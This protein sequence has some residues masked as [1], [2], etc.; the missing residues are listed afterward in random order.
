MTQLSMVLGV[1]T[2]LAYLPCSP[3]PVGLVRSAIKTVPLLLFSLSA[4]LGNGGAFLVA[5]L[6][7]SA[8]GDFALSR[9][10]AALFLYGLSAF[11]LAHVVYILHFSGLADAPLYEAFANHPVPAL[12]LVGLVVSTE[13]WLIPHTGA[14]RWPV[15]IYVLIIGLMGLSA[16]GAPFGWAVVGA[17][18][19]IISDVILAVQ[20]FR[21]SETY[22][23]RSWAGYAV[24]AF[25]VSGQFM[26]LWGGLHG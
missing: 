4:Y 6:F 2:A 23:Y 12:A 15:R 21:M 17:G 9:D 14:L 13:L 18:V 8:L 5:G 1:L 25:Y 26:I 22:R 7:L 24:W 20:L 16:L 3:A 10:G 11:A 19:F